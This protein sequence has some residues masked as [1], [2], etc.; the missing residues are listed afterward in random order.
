MCVGLGCEGSHFKSRQN[1]D[2]VL[3]VEGDARTQRK[4]SNPQMII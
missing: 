4:A 2:C 1:M 3:V